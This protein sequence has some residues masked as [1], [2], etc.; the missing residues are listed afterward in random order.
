MFISF[1]GDDTTESKKIALSW[2]TDFLAHKLRHFLWSVHFDTLKFRRSSKKERNPGKLRPKS[3][4]I[5]PNDKF[6]SNFKMD[7]AFIVFH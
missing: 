5:N 7:F 1:I 6:K 3:F 2:K 4:Y